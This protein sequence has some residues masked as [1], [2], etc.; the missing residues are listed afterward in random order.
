MNAIENNSMYH[1]NPEAAEL[2]R[3]R[4]FDPL[5]YVRTTKDGIVLDL[6]YKKLWFRMRYPNG[7]IRPLLIKM[8]EETAIVEACVFF[9]RRDTEPA[10]SAIAQCNK[11]KTL[12]GEY[13]KVAQ[14]TAIDRALSDAG[15]GIQFIPAESIS[16]QTD[17]VPG[18]ASDTIVD[19]VVPS[20]AHTNETPAAKE[21]VP[22]TVAT[23]AS[24]KEQLTSELP[25]VTTD[26]KPIQEIIFTPAAKMMTCDVEGDSDSDADTEPVDEAS[27]IP[28]YTSDTPV[29][30]I[31]SIMTME[32]AEN[33][34]VGEGTCTGWS[35]SKVAERRPASLKFYINGYKGKDNI[36][37]AA[38]TLMMRKA[39]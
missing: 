35:M 19:E 18:E 6:P 26:E 2:N 31:C 17:Y 21:G 30:E 39:S 27:N 4:G 28:R 16:A 22:Q 20:S 24:D 5:N 29:E 33:Y 13:L 12:H 36:L 23:T 14:D 34:V 8:T 1:V 11:N 7:K 3:V 37:R 10:S 9:D 15:F 25:V 38:A 32:E